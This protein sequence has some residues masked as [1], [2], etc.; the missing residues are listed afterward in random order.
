[1]STWVIAS[2]PATYNAEGSLEANGQM[3]WVMHNKFE[4]GDVRCRT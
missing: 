1:M 4:L 3:E 2:N